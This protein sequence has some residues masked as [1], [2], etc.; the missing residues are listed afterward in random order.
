MALNSPSGLRLRIQQ[1]RKNQVIA[2]R[3][4]ARILHGST[5]KTQTQVLS[6]DVSLMPS[7][8]SSPAKLKRGVYFIAIANSDTDALPHWYQYQF[9]AVTEADGPAK[10]QLVRQG[11]KGSGAP[12]FDYIV[13]SVG[14]ASETE[15]HSV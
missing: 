5:H 1:Q 2:D 15:T 14:E 13:L 3:L 4:V 6:G 10:R 8:Q 11:G 7:P 12:P 9:Q